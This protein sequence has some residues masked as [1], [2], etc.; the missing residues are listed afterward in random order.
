MSSASFFVDNRLWCIILWRAL[1]VVRLSINVNG[2]FRLG[3]ESIDIQPV[4]IDACQ[5]CG[6]R[7]WGKAV[8][9]VIRVV[10]ID[11]CSFSRSY[12]RFEWCRLLLSWWC[13]ATPMRTAKRH[14]T[15]DFE[16]SFLEF[17]KF[18]YLPNVIIYNGTD[19]V[20][21]SSFTP[22]LSQCFMPL[23]SFRILCNLSF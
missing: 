10:L 17:L 16:I 6:I 11:A 22:F 14:W 3:W 21:L 9:I 5:F 20:P 12:G 4:S 8:S 13:R 15:L 19:V 1:T 18:H 23:H 2:Q 7:D